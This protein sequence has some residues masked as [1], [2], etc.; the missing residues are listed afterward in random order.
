MVYP[1]VVSQPRPPILVIGGTGAQ[2]GATARALLARGHRVRVLARNPTSPAALDLRDSGAELIRGDLDDPASLAAAVRG[3]AGVFSVQVP[4]AKGDDSER[5]HGTAL[6]QAARAAGVTHFVHTS[7]TGTAQRTAFPR[8]TSGYWSQKYWNDK[9]HVEEAVRQ[10]GFAVWTVLRPAFLM[11]N[12]A[13]PKS[14]Y[15]FP[16]LKH[17]EIATALHPHTRM[18]LIAAD[19]VGAF[20]AAAFSDAGR[21]ASQ[22]IDLAAEALTMEEV[23]GAL[24]EA[25]GRKVV[26]IALTPEQAVVRGLHPGWVRSQEW[27]N[28]VGYQADIAG[29]ARWGLPLTSFAS[30]ARQR[31]LT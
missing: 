17:G 1:R 27:T 7:V 10:A 22:E 19:D 24:T 3:V 28:E 5:R 16:H 29:L 21:F 20:A 12:F 13:R 8:W 18:Q 9:W 26:A 30:W 4:D 23:A 11:D 25:L 2:G 15:M 31:I 14:A 6:V